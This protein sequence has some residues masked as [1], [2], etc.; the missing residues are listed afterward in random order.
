MIVIYSNSK[1]FGGVEILIHRY[2]NYL[3]SKGVSFRLIEMKN[4]KL[5]KLVDEAYIIEPDSIDEIKNEMLYLFLPNVSKL[6]ELP[7][8]L[9]SNTSAKVCSWIVHPNEVFTNFIPYSIS[10]MSLL[11]YQSSKFSSF[12]MPKHYKMIGDLFYTLNKNKSLLLMDNAC[13]R[14]LIYFF[15]SVKFKFKFNIT[16]IP[17]PVLP[18]KMLE[19]KGSC[20]NDNSIGYF[21]RM[22]RTK[23]SAIKPFIENILSKQ[24][25]PQL[26]VI[27]VGDKMD[28]LHSL[29]S[30]YGIKI[31]DYGFQPNETAR[32]IIKE[33]TNIAIAMG[34]SALDIAAEGHPCIILDP[35]I[36]KKK[37]KQFKFRFVHEIEGYTLGEFRDF[38]NYKL[39]LHSFGE[40]L[41]MIND[42]LRKKEYEYVKNKHNPEL[43][44]NAVTNSLYKSELKISDLKDSISK[45][46]KSFKSAKFN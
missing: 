36:K 35:A 32:R 25:C 1:T 9:F 7:N 20:V 30:K 22:D 38:P 31:I 28:E 8:E 6:T 24:K 2:I 15:S 10:L 37:S 17:V 5:A 42:N 41:E 26:H 43:I 11:G 23:Y 29:C 19:K 21:G 40:C 33:N 27:A 18:F 3:K 45:I 13:E 16:A 46:K 12:I 39:G 34:T 14:S 44:F 4:T